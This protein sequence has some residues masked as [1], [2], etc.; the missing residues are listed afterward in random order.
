MGTHRKLQTLVAV[1]TAGAALAAGT[2]NFTANGATIQ[3]R[4][5]DGMTI[6]PANPAPVQQVAGDCAAACVLSAEA[7]TVQGLN[8]WGFTTTPGSLTLPGPTIVV[9]QGDPVT[10]T[11]TNNLPVGAGDLKIELPS[12]DVADLTASPAIA[13]GTSGDVTFTANTVGTSIY[14]ASATTP[15]GNL[16]AAM[17]LAGVLVVRPA[18]CPVAP[19]GEWA[20]CTYSDLT[21]FDDEALLAMNDLDPVLAA[22]PTV[23]DLLA[24]DMTD[25]HPSLHL[26]NGKV[27]PDTD[28]IDTQPG[29]EVLIRYANLGLADHSMGLSGT[30]QLIVGRDSH[31]L[32]HASTDV[33]VPLNVGQT[34]DAIVS[35]PTNA[36]ASYRYA[37]SDQVIQTGA[38][39][40]APAMTFLAVW[41]EDATPNTTG[42]A[43]HVV[44]I[45]PDQSAGNVD[46]AFNGTI[47]LPSGVSP[48]VG[49]T[50][51][52]D[53]PGA[54]LP[55]AS[56]NVLASTDPVAFESTFEGTV[57]ASE[58]SFLTN[59]THIL[60][61]QLTDG[62]NVGD[63]AG[64]A[65]TID[66]AGP[67][68][69]PVELDPAF[70][71]GGVDVAITATADASL[72]G[73]DSVTEG[74]ATIGTCPDFATQPVA[75]PGNY[76]LVVNAVQPI[77]ELTGTIPAAEVNSLGDGT[78][79]VFVSA[80]DTLGVWSNDGAGTGA[81]S[82][83]SSADLVVDK[84]APT[85]ISGYTDP[86]GPNDGTQGV[87]TVDGFLEVVRIFA[88]VNDGVSGVDMVEGA[89]DLTGDG[90][91]ADDPTFM[92]GPIDGTWGPVGNEDVY[93]DIP[94]ASLRTLPPGTYDV[95]VR[96]HDNAGN[97]GGALAVTFLQLVSNPPVI[98]TLTY[99]P[100]GG[101]TAITAAAFGVDVTV[102][103]IEWSVGPTA[104]AAGAGNGLTLD[105]PHGQVA[106][107]V[108]A[109][110]TFGAIP[111]GS[112][113]W[114]RAMDSGNNWGPATGLP[115]V[116]NLTVVLP[117]RITGTATSNGTGGIMAVE[118]HI[119]GTATAPWINVSLGNQVG[120]LVVNFTAQR[121]NAQSAFT[122][123]TVW[124]RTQDA[125]GNWGPATSISA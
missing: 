39:S 43:A 63:P 106:S 14:R 101:S 103:A 66:R 60:W 38:N 74:N 76:P 86:A 42:P 1:A 70:T 19:A 13:E 45:T 79:T 94:L 50:F 18:G 55:G 7:G 41:A 97:W 46:L 81:A 12:V 9:N 52:I 36:K 72:T 84:T 123:N 95:L 119:G 37:L 47:S 27:F 62:V 44:A 109:S 104:A 56:S 91:S 87:S 24:F 64:I 32:P 93:A 69:Q 20:G 34:V 17:G 26:I 31:L 122:G 75:L 65:F 51:S 88:T 25:F 117:R 121:S 71:N 23:A 58:L 112:N 120:S 6:S 3:Q 15:H 29:H 30:R 113:L 107:V 49:G 2:I 21:D 118:Y 59:G 102:E 48:A 108:V 28:A 11:V 40:A 83:C 80:A 33:V 100:G 57:L 67:V 98:S 77:A 73:T 124:F 115:T 68:V 114:V 96:A 90:P 82:V 105:V 54:P 5:V 110:A 61:V 116:S 53:D 16:Q 99:E 35:I 85:A 22:L 92:F 89:I 111:S 4:L 125:Q 8:V 10:L 78:Y